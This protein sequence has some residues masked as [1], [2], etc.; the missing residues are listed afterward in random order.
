MPDF[1]SIEARDRRPCF[2]LRISGV[3]VT[4]GTV[5]PRTFT[6][7]H[8]ASDAGLKEYKKSSSIIPGRGFNFEREMR[9][10]EGIVESAPVSVFLAV[11]QHN[12]GEDESDPGHVFGR[13]GYESADF[14]AQ[15]VEQIEHENNPTLKLTT[16]GGLSTGDFIHI[17]RE[18]MEVGVVNLGQK[19]VTITQRGALG[20]T[21]VRHRVSAVEGVFP[22][23][24]KPAVFFRG[25]RAVIYEGALDKNGNPPN[26]SDWIERY[27]G[28][29]AKEPEFSTDGRLNVV[30]VEVS[31]LTAALDRPVES[32]AGDVRLHTRLHTFDGESASDLK[33]YESVRSAEYLNLTVTQSHGAGIFS[34]N[35]SNLDKLLPV[36]ANGDP[37]L[38]P[39]EHIRRVPLSYNFGFSQGALFYI[40]GIDS[41][42]GRVH[43]K[44]VFN[45]VVADAPPTLV[46]PG[47]LPKT[48]ENKGIG[49]AIWYRFGQRAALA[50]AGAA[51][52]LWPEIL[53]K[54]NNQT[55]AFGGN[56]TNA[57]SDSLFFSRFSYA[58]NL[59]ASA[60]TVTPNYGFRSSG[61]RF[62]DIVTP[63]AKTQLT[64]EP[65]ATVDP[66]RD[67][68]DD[69]VAFNLPTRI[70][71]NR[72]T[73][74]PSDVAIVL[75]TP[76]SDVGQSH[77]PSDVVRFGDDPES[78]GAT[79]EVNINE[80]TDRAFF[81][82]EVPVSI[83]KAFYTAGPKGEPIRPGV[84][85]QSRLAEKWITFDRDPGV[86]T[87]GRLDLNVYIGDDDERV[88][89][90]TIGEAV[91]KNISGETGFR[92]QVYKALIFSEDVDRSIVDNGGIIA[93]R[94]RFV[95]GVQFS[96]TATIGEIALQLLTSLDGAGVTSNEFDVL[97]FGAGL[98]HT[99]FTTDFG[100]DVDVDSFLA[101][102]NVAGINVAP[103]IKSGDTLFEVL[104]PLLQLAGYGV[105][106]AV[107][108]QGRCRLSAVP[109]GL[110]NESVVEK[111]IVD[112]DMADTPT[113][114]SPAS[115]EIRNVFKFESNFDDKDDAQ[116]KK[117]VRDTV[118][119][120]TF[121]E[122]GSISISLPGV[123]LPTDPAGLTQVLRP[124]FSRLRA[125]MAYPRRLFRFGVRSGLASRLKVGATYK[126]SSSFLRGL[127]GVG[128]ANAVCRLRRVQSDGF[129]PIARVE[130]IFFGF[131]GA[132]WGPSLEVTS[133][134]AAVL[135]VSESAFRPS[136]EFEDLD[137]FAS[138]QPGDTVVVMSGA[139][140]DAFFTR[141]VSSVD[142]AANTITLTANAFP[143]GT[144]LGTSPLAFVV[145]VVYA[146]S[147]ALHQPY[148][149]L[150]R[151]K[152]S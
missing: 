16:V 22:L 98:T 26:A 68:R 8:A 6:Y 139:Y 59:S 141:T 31:P 121:G 143:A 83:A 64:S 115:L 138:L 129:D 25:R 87:G 123:Q 119:I 146:S 38:K 47:S 109:F 78:L 14:S 17:G 86:P 43:L 55:L 105:D 126:I 100:I 42:L 116:L 122:A 34:A 120:D 106:M 36:D 70:F 20:T 66:P 82:V 50:S 85:D 63:T 134:N 99:E 110:P 76:F 130:F 60:V 46:G 32:S 84:F 3:P 125:E 4:F 144:N 13:L 74:D 142:K 28:F 127:S 41:A 118:S 35:V 58:F 95:A 48:L 62:N 97:P 40:E 33:F 23:V 147:P 102:P 151:T 150:N 5:N 44:R 61:N 92:C 57:G 148:S 77:I 49:E 112:A 21:K 2:M 108:D 10:D 79:V 131:N 53:E 103:R 67:A 113:P 72:I 93:D 39:L 90:L 73:T 137:G 56:K 81:A 30:R 117:N 104:R 27:R 145:P 149:F 51:T 29:V 65:L 128:V 80:N 11:N 140:T 135:T 45:G 52:D 19:T 94:P 107:D 1:E 89:C 54:Y 114:S 7:V 18:A 12:D 96:N 91:T 124:V 136:E 132:G 9:P 37:T 101:I 69:Q 71:F 75:E 133:V 24:T 88:A 152:M 111:H 15:L